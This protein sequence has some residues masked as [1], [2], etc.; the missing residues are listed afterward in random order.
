M[1]VAWKSLDVRYGKL[2]E[3]ARLVAH[4]KPRSDEERRLLD[5][6]EAMNLTYDEW[7][8]FNKSIAM[9]QMPSPEYLPNTR[10]HIHYRQLRAL[11]PNAG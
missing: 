6:A 8:D 1:M 4:S 11:E 2:K 3:I 9:E 10:P 7:K 5:L